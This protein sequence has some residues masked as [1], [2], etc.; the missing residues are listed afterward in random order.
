MSEKLLLKFPAQLHNFRKT[1]IGDNLIT[2]SVDR[3]YSDQIIDVIRK[4]IGTE[5][6]IYLEDVTSETNLNE[7]SVQVRERFVHKMHALLG[8]LAELSGRDKEAEKTSLKKELIKKGLIKESTKELN[9][10]GLGIACNIVEEMINANR[11]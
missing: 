10:K 4:E 5:F 6:V 2:F 11:N 1:T 3:A 7:D 8:E 9:L